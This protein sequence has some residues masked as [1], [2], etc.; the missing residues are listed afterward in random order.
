MSH[1]PEPWKLYE[2]AHI[3]GVED[4]E[5]VIAD[6]GPETDVRCRANARRIVACVNFCAGVSTEDLERLKACEEYF[7]N[8]HELKT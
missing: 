6:C 4:H 7:R 3:V 5:R 2:D 1:S 8:R